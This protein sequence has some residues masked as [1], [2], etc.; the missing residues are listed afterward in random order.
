ML[1]RLAALFRRTQPSI[2]MP[3]EPATIVGD[4]AWCWFA[5]PRAVHHKGTRDATYVGSVTSTGDIRIDS[6]ELATGCSESAV[7]H[8]DLD[9]NDHANPSLMIDRDGRVTVFYSAHNGSTI[10][11]RRSAQPEDVTAWLPETELNLNRGDRGRNAYTYP[12]PV[13]TSGGTTYLFWRGDGWKP[14]LSVSHDAGITWDES[15]VVVAGA[16]AD[17]TNRPYV[18]VSGSSHRIDMAFTDGHP[19]DEASNSV[20]YASLQAGRFNKADGRKIKALDELPFEPSEADCVYDAEQHGAR[21]W[22][23]DVACDTD[24]KPAVVFSTFPADD[25]HIYWYARWAGRR[26]VT[27]EI[28]SGGHWFPEDVA[29]KEQTEPHYSGGI[30]LDHSDLNAVYLSRPVDGVFEIERAVTSDMGSSWDHTPVTS[31]SLHDNVR[32]VAIR[33]ASDRGPRVMWMEVSGWYLGYKEYKTSIR[34]A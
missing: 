34:M 28:T 5:D 19:R 26:W 27:N 3:R 23:W 25:R 12:T 2:P 22:V 15:R 29:D 17:D 24:R 9:R 10:F 8:E 16:G 31:G 18:K 21:A 20:Y 7:L 14:T 30:V 4:G 1:N 6:Y 33:N 11:S 32:P 13:Q